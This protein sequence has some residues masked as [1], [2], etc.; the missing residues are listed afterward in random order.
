V[1]LGVVLALDWARL[2]CAEP[3]PAPGNVSEAR[4]HFKRGLAFVERNELETALTEFEAAYEIQPHYSVLYNLGQAYSAL[5]RPT[6]AIDAFEHYLKDGAANVDDARRAEVEGLI[7]SDRKRL[8]QVQFELSSAQEQRLWLDGESLDLEK[9]RAPISVAV[10]THSLLYSAGAGFPATLEFLVARGELRK[11]AVPEP[12]ILNDAEI[13]VRCEIPDV[14]ITVDGVQMGRTPGRTTLP[15][16]SG[17]HEILLV[18][19]NYLPSRVSVAASAARAL[20]LECALQPLSP[21]PASQRAWLDLKTE[22]SSAATFIDGRRWHGEP[23]PAGR[24]SLR[25]EHAGYVPQIRLIA[26]APT[27][28]LSLAI[29]LRKTSQLRVREEEAAASRRT[30]SYFLGGAG[31]ALIGTGATLHTINSKRFDDWQSNHSTTHAQDL[32]TVASIQR[33]DDA[34]V[35][36]I[37]AGAGLA[38]GGAWLF[39]SRNAESSD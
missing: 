27:R 37:F 2:A 31:L 11:V 7:A 13:D 6:K 8:G 25:S 10:G 15:V 33:L 19:A 30:W 4:E 17:L 20:T 35:G 21:I 38:V 29:T 36:L 1:G 34:S 32:S 12:P 23:L 3:S 28:T 39:L 26:I 14:I 9:A 16:H 24:H 5:G 22:P 18:R